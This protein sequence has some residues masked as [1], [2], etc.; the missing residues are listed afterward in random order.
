MMNPVPRWTMRAKT[1]LRDAFLYIAT[2]FYPGYAVAFETMCSA[3]R[4]PFPQIP[5]SV[6]KH[7]RT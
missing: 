1:R 2:N 4:R 3:L 5:K 7:S 6:L